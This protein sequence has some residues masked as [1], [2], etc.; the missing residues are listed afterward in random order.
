[1]VTPPVVVPPPVVTPPV[2]V[3]PPVVTPP[4]VPSTN[5]QPTPVV[6]PTPSGNPLPPV[7]VDLIPP[8][9][10]TCPLTVTLTQGQALPQPVAIDNLSPVVITRS[11][12]T[13][14]PVGKTTVI[15]TASDQAGLS[16]KCIQ[17]VQIKPEVLER[18]AVTTA[19]CT[20]ISETQGRWLIQGSST[21]KNNSIQL[22]TTATVPSDVN[23][24]T[25]GEAVSFEKK[26]WRLLEKRGPACVPNISIRTASGKVFEGTSVK[27][28]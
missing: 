28:K 21:L 20:K 9:F 26:T 16:S 1:V 10:T 19:Q 27:I 23:S 17:R 24:N 13:S 7:I 3:P 15:W 6:N 8:K 18:I 22:Y 12:T 11:P 4:P 14:L 2:V 5:P 25:L